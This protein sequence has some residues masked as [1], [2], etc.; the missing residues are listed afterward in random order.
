MKEIKVWKIDKN[1]ILK[2]ICFPQDLSTLDLI[3]EILPGGAYTTFRT[4]GHFRAFCFDE[5]LRRLQNTAKLDGNPVKIDHDEIRTY[6][7]QIIKTFPDQAELRIRISIDLEKEIGDE[8][9]MAEILQIPPEVAY[10][11][12]V[13]AITCDFKRKNPKAKLTSHVSES[14]RIR[15][16]LKAGINEALL[17]DDKGYILEG[18]S[19]NFFAVINRQ[20]WT[21]ESRVLS[22]ITRRI[23]LERAN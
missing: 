5:H 22:G 20:L 23:T 17:V 8:Y 7:R 18:L 4:Y 15:R 11:N 16:R 9:F 12:G 1:K 13:K 14:I 2:G 3:S 19:S 10:R 21:A 6:V